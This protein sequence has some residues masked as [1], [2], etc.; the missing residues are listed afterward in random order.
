[1]SVAVLVALVGLSPLSGQRPDYTNLQSPPKP[2][3]AW[4]RMIDQGAFDPRLKG[5]FTPAGIRV[6]IVADYPVVVNP[7]GMTFAEDGTPYVLEWVPG[8]SHWNETPDTVTYKDG[9]KRQFM[10]MKKPVP[11]VVKTLHDTQR[12]GVYNRSEVV[13]RD[14]LPSS[15]LLHDGWLYLTG[16][17]SVRRY[18]QSRPGG[19]YDVKEIVAQ[20]FCGFHHH[21][22]SGLT[23]GNEG[24]LYITSGDDDNVAEGSDGSRATVLR[25][26]G[27]FRCR[28]D[29]SG[30][31]VFAVGFR[32]PYRDV[33]F[34]AAFNM[35]HAD[36]DNEDGSKFTGCRL[37]HVAEAGDY[38]WRLRAGAHCCEPDYARG[39]V[40]GELPGTLPILLKTGRG[41]PAGLLI[42]NDTYFPKEYRGLLYYPDV[43]RKLIRAYRVEPRRASF[44]VVEEFEL[45]KSDDPLFRP[46]QMVLGPDGAMYVVDWRTN[47]GGAGQLYGDAAHG[48]IYRLRWAGTE[49]EAAL[50][51]RGMD[52]W[53]RIA[54]ASE[55]ELLQ[56]LASANFSDR[57][58]AQRRLVKLG[59][60]VR[61]ALLKLLGDR[62]KPLPAR[63]HALG[64]LESFWDDG[65]REAF[66][67]CLDDD[68]PELR[69][70][71]A[72]GLAQNARAADP[73]VFASLHHH[74]TDPDLAVR[75]AAALALGRLAPPG[76]EDSLVT[77]LLA[78]HGRD[79][80]LRDGLV[81]AVERLGPRGIDR[82][83]QAAESGVDRDRDRVVEAFLALRTRPAAE[84]LPR[85]LGNPHLRPEQRAALV[86]SYGNYL[87]D[88]PVSLEP[89][90]EA[91]AGGGELE[92]V[93]LAALEVFALPG[94]VRG[95]RC[96]AAMLAGLDER[97]PRLRLAAVTALEEARVTA[98]APRLAQVL[99]DGARPEAERIT[100][101][102][103]LRV[104]WDE[105]VV[106]ALQEASRDRKQSPAFRAETLRTLGHY[107]FAEAQAPARE[108]LESKESG[109]QRAAVWVLAEV[110]EG[111]KLLGERFVAR[112]L[113][114]ELLPQVCDALRKH[115]EKDPALAVLLT[116]VMKGGL[117]VS[118]DKGNVER[119]ERLVKTKGDPRRGKELYLDNKVLAC[120][121]CHK[122]EGVGGEVGP[123]LTGIWENQSVEKIMESIIDPSKE[124]KEGYK[125]YTA[126]TTKGQVF[127]GLRVSQDA[128]GIVLRDAD[129]KEVRIPADQLAAVEASPK[130]LMPDNAV[131]Q[132]TFDQFIDLIAFLKDRAAQESL[133]GTVGEFRAVGPFAGDLAA[134]HEPEEK[135]EP[136]AGY[137][138]ADGT[139]LDWQRCAT[140]PYGRLDLK[141][142]LVGPQTVAYALVYVFSPRA[143]P[144]RLLLGSDDPVKVWVNGTVAY[145]CTSPRLPAPDQDEAEVRLR[146]G[147]NPV[148]VKVAHAGAEHA[149]YL[150]L[151]G[152][153]LEF[154][155]DPINK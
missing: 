13:L 33:A 9:T 110:P 124:I 118:L 75:R 27:V 74:L 155:R 114:P 130:S 19:P 123:A 78:D 113:P 152:E 54:R 41:A 115:A 23:L 137:T 88:P 119:V 81:Q 138:R 108:F 76:A 151:V 153:G 84:A 126:A 80:Y 79:T 133:R 30:L 28:P 73:D 1:L 56:A 107:N 85:L 55:A 117:L 69:R 17:G 20:G 43:F 106:P 147:W 93:T 68:S 16:R 40:S 150:R 48:R 39:A 31:E 71:A 86:K 134:A 144:A 22:V 82:L 37:M 38:G 35:F 8:G 62:A 139:R 24:R 26:G 154:A 97:E 83:L 7:V 11:D 44:E 10:T 59:P 136:T 145:Q 87:F 111:A 61:P 96:Q 6:E 92:A 95:P 142:F 32:N 72:D 36:N 116:E 143:Q 25:T 2:A 29:G 57:R 122:L 18:R 132:L 94:V 140:Q 91:L 104:L 50:P 121:T 103:A 63:V 112:K 101:V 70:L 131:A 53:A 141:P 135:P 98:A 99:R 5:Y 77:A 102:K 149:L 15:I 67:K 3:P 105:S 100:A 49:N 65:V 120:V 42:Y 58:V 45:L 34:D 46:C 125:A 90:A 89:L 47:S 12:K 51:L 52:S 129:G 66:V 146:P 21:Q 128:K 109:L 4:V 14:E 60:G 127:T 64:A 148:L